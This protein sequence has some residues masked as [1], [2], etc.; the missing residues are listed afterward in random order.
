MS[1]NR[2]IETHKITFGIEMSSSTDVGVC[3][4]CEV[5]E[6]VFLPPYFKSFES[7]MSTGPSYLVHSGVVGKMH[8]K[9][10]LGSQYY[11]TM[12][13]DL[14]RVSMVRFIKNKLH[15]LYIISKMMIRLSISLG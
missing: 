5:S 15:V 3:T 12:M 4:Y 9:V 7:S 10:L 6:S 11:V 13:D 8:V 1:L 14:R 2:M